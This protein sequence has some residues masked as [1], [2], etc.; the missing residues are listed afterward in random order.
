LLT[1]CTTL[2]LIQGQREALIGEVLDRL[3]T[4]MEEGVNNPS[5]LHGDLWSGNFLPTRY[6]GFTSSYPTVI[7]PA[8]YFGSR[9]IELAY[10]ELFGGFPRGFI[11]H[12]RTVWPLPDGYER[13]RPVLQLYPLLVH[14]LHFGEK[15]GPP[16]E[17]A[18]RV[19]LIS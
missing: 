14:L 7:D 12:Y 9:E 16:L 19:A 5:L 10:I 1:R 3:H 11:E 15:Y 17:H 2:G 13:R 4:L 18:C 8:A 6:K